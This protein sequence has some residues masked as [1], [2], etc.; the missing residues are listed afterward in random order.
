[1]H[2]NGARLD[3][4]M[5]W[6]ADGSVWQLPANT[7]TS[8]DGGE[9]TVV[10]VDD[11]LLDV[12][13]PAPVDTT[14]APVPVPAETAPVDSV[15]VGPTETVAPIPGGGL[16]TVP[17]D[18]SIAPVGDPTVETA[19]LLV[20]LSVD[21]ATKVAEDNGWVLRVSTLDGESQIVTADFNTSRVNVAVAA[22]VVTGIDSIG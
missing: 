6:A 4:T 5:V 13:A 1:V 7:F 2:L 16:G 8:A 20:G 21:E 15:V 12:P 14:P 17:P 9:Y 19:A 18:F 10:A 11:S 22:G 3:L